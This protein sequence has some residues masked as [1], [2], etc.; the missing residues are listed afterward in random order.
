MTITSAADNQGTAYLLNSP[1][2]ERAARVCMS[3]V[4]ESAKKP[5]LGQLSS[6]S[7]PLP[8]YVLSP[9]HSEQRA[10]VC[11]Q[12]ALK[13]QS[14][15][16][17]PFALLEC[18]HNIAEQCKAQRGPG[19]SSSLGRNG[20]HPMQSLGRTPTDLCEWTAKLV[21]SLLAP[22]STGTKPN[23]SPDIAV[24]QKLQLPPGP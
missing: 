14:C 22:L 23:S 24:T 8:A 12:G 6:L 2:Q 19:H 7:A 1:S 10:V 5:S 18:N 17:Y 9:D 11:F 16:I 4:A 20:P 13:P 15:P 3:N 21:P